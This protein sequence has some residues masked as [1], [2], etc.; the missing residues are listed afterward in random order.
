MLPPAL[1]LI[2]QSEASY[3]QHSWNTLHIT[4]EFL[5]RAD[6]VD[7][8]AS[9]LTSSWSADGLPMSS[10]A[11]SGREKLS[12]PMSSWGAVWEVIPD[13]WVSSTS[14]SSI[15]F[16]MVLDPWSWTWHESC[17]LAPM[18]SISSGR[19]GE[20][21]QSYRGFGVRAFYPC[22]SCVHPC[23][24]HHHPYLHLHLHL[25][26]TEHPFQR[27]SHLVRFLHPPHF[28]VKAENP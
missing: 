27:S 11:S 18:L 4:K 3:N 24:C 21:C 13:S 23:W 25:Q 17:A 1:S 8:G 9:I 28:L 5:S 16:S 20:S 7:G 6:S 26:M 15:F 14:V 19:G 2:T 12:S 10:S 22:Q